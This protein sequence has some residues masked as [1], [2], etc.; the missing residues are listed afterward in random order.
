MEG[1]PQ[2][3]AAA[4]LTASSGTDRHAVNCRPG[5]HAFGCGVPGNSAI[6]IPFQPGNHVGPY[7]TD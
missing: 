4:R 5:L 6:F 3:S 2:G 7:G 1:T